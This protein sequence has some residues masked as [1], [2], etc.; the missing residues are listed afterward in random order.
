MN[1]LEHITERYLD[2][3]LSPAELTA[4]EALLEA[5]SEAR[6]LLQ[7]METIRSAAR[8]FPELSHPDPG[9]ESALFQQLFAEEDWAPAVE[10]EPEKRRR[11]A[12]IPL[13]RS[14]LEGMAAVRYGRAAMALPALLLLLFLGDRF[15][16]STVSDPVV[17]S[18]EIAAVVTPPSTSAPVESTGGTVTGIRG[19]EDAPRLQS[20]TP[21]QNDLSPLPPTRRPLTID[22]AEKE[23]E[24]EKGGV[25]FADLF[26]RPENQML[27]TTREPQVDQTPL[28]KGPSTAMAEENFGSRNNPAPSELP[29]FDR[30]DFER[31]DRPSTSTDEVSTLSASY[32]HGVSSFFGERR[33]VL[34]SGQDMNLRIEGQIAERHRVSVVV[35]SSPVLVAERTYRT[36][37]SILPDPKGGPTTSSVE[38]EESNRI[39]GE[40]WAGVGYG[41]TLVAI[42]NVRIEAGVNAGYGGQSTRYGLEL[43]A[44]IAVTDRIGVEVI[45]YLTRIL[46]RDQEVRGESA[47]F[48]AAEG[49][50]EEWTPSSTSVGAQVGLSFSIR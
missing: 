50:R 44:R 46:P 45:P 28:P 1:E 38:I 34:A 16:G 7:S 11:A 37:S 31:P 15:L 14:G 17:P 6:E 36:Q 43:P 20:T 13:F 39:D 25:P 30:S 42:D 4:Y 47:R 48:G 26:D 49:Y 22:G 2:G 18:S 19:T 29:Q 35:G 40:V 27:E 12:I 8:S 10:E 21:V 5:S 41:Y 3:E 9:L 23:G 33:P 32:R 24:T